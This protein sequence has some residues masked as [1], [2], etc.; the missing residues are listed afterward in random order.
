[1]SFD[2]WNFWNNTSKMR[3]RR[4]RVRLL[5]RRA[6]KVNVCHVARSHVLRLTEWDV[7]SVMRCSV[8][9]VRTRNSF[10]SLAS[11]LLLQGSL[12]WEQDEQLCEL[13]CDHDSHSRECEV[14]NVSYC[15]TCKKI[16]MKKVRVGVL[17]VRLRNA[18]LTHTHDR[19]GKKPGNVSSVSE[20]RRRK[21]LIRKRLQQQRT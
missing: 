12:L 5:S 10:P 17:D 4:Y 7:S 20:Q 9:S 18:S 11:A 14:C 8:K 1:M 19:W 3:F 6:W 13:W 16:K 15:V 2:R 21:R